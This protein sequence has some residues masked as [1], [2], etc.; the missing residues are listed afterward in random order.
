MHNQSEPGLIVFAVCALGTLA[1]VITV[2]VL[3]HRSALLRHTERL[4]AMDKGLPIPADPL[5]TK[6]A[7]SPRI[8]L[9]RGLIWLFTGF[10]LSVFL[11]GISLSTLRPVPMERRLNDAQWMRQRGNPEAEVQQYLQSHE[12]DREGL[13]YGWALIGMIPMGVG[14]AYIVFYRA[15]GR[16]MTNGA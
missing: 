13:P 14:L 1:I 6:A 3:R 4:T 2:L 16:K 15:E 8:Y 11:T 10:G 12:R 5:P 7:W 9:L